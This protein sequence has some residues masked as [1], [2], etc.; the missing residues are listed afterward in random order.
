MFHSILEI[1][2]SQNLTHRAADAHFWEKAGDQ[3]IL[4]GNHTIGIERQRGI[5]QR[6]YDRA[7]AAV[8]GWCFSRGAW[9]FMA[10]LFCLH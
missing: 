9:L 8:G 6:L 5:G 1:W 7:P 4:V 3:P 10:R 2:I